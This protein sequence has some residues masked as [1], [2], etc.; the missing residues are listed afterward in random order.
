MTINYSGYQSELP[1]DP[2][3]KCKKWKNNNKKNPYNPIALFVVL[4]YPVSMI[5]VLK[6]YFSLRQPE[7]FREMSDSSLE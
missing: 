4:K 2:R 5:V 6:Y 1:M 7:F 3:S